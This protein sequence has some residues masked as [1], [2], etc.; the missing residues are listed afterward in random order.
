MPKVSMHIGRKWS[1][2]HN[3]REYDVGKWN[4]DGHIETERSDLNKVLHNEELRSFFDRTFGDALVEFNEKN[5]SKHPE[6]LIGFKSAAEYDAATPEERRQRAVN[7]Y[8]NE[9]KGKVQECIIQM[10][11][12]EDYMQLVASVGRERADKI[13]EEFLQK[14]YQQWLSENPSLRVFAAIAHLDETKDGTPH[15]HIDFIP[16]AESS[17]G[18]T[19]K[20]SMDGAM[21]Q[22][23]YD[24]KTKAKDGE[25]DKYADT[26]YKRW[27]GHHRERVEQL[28][29]EF[30]EITPS[31]HY[32]KQKR[33]ET[34]QWR[35]EQK[36]Q[37][38]AEQETVIAHNEE[39]INRQNST[40]SDNSSFIEQ[41]EVTDGETKTVKGMFGKEKE[42][43]KSDEEVQRDKEVRAAQAII[44]RER[45]VEQ[46]EKAV[47]TLIA[48]AVQKAVQGERSEGDRKLKKLQEKHAAELEKQRKEL[49]AQAARTAQENEQLKAERDQYKKR[50]AAMEDIALDY[51]YLVKEILEEHPMPEYGQT[52]KAYWNDLQALTNP[53]PTEQKKSKKKGNGYPDLD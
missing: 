47:D 4:T 6:R 12:H 43:P 21:K 36:E 2:K 38:L 16:T 11:N 17:R 30:M 33:Q 51:G 53:E 44:K 13:H 40:I 46:R 18:L 15:I 25:N 41:L 49:T 14:A 39:I 20:V 37:E 28:A 23:G 42:V 10:G 27:L 31:E 34:W 35:A 9:Q 24:R 5:K 48:T 1:S 50:S 19:V 7:A 29:G 32:S 52:E 8:Y 3:L 45:A 22:L 26:P